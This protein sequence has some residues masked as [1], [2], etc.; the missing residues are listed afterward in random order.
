M[1]RGLAVVGLLALC[2][3]VGIISTALRS[4]HDGHAAVAAWND[5]AERVR[6]A[7][8]A[9]VVS[10]AGREPVQWCVSCLA[11]PAD[12]SVVVD[13]VTFRVCS[14]CDLSGGQS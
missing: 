7:A 8:L 5:R 11:Q 10:P 6:A 9:R 3:L 13:G 2:M 12:R 4:T 14:G 1:I